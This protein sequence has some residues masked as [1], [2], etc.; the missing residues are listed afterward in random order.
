VTGLHCFSF[1]SIFP[2]PTLSFAFLPPFPAF[3]FTLP[4]FQAA[5]LATWLISILVSPSAAALSP[6]AFV[7]IFQLFPPSPCLSLAAF[8]S[9][10]P[11]SVFSFHLFPAL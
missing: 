2:F 10:F 8:A 4:L 7:S 11:P 6:A 3:P 9:P 1:S 5:S